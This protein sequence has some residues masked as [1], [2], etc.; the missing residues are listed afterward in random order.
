[1]TQL[2]QQ[3]F[4]FLIAV[5]ASFM[6]VSG[7][8][9]GSVNAEGTADVEGWINSLAET[10]DPCGVAELLAKTGDLRALSPL[11]ELIQR[12]KNK[13]VQ[14]CAA[15]ALA[16][17][18]TKKS[19]ALLIAELNNPDGRAAVGAAF[20]LGIIK[21]DAAVDPLLK[22]FFESETLCFTAAV[23]LG[24]I[25]APRSLDPL[26]GALK[27]QSA[28][29]RRCAIWGLGDFGDRRAC[30]GLLDVFMAVWSQGPYADYAHQFWA[31]ESIEQLQCS[32]DAS[33]T[34]K[35]KLSNTCCNN[36]RQL[37]EVIVPLIE[38]K[39]SPREW[40]SLL[41]NDT[42]YAAFVHTFSDNGDSDFGNP[43]DQMQ[44]FVINSSILAWGEA[45]VFFR[46]APEGET[47]D[48]RSFRLNQVFQVKRL[49]TG[50]RFSCPKIK[51]PD[52]TRD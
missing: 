40:G 39:P 23:A 18:D 52:Y 17:L 19:V 16:N 25:K 4:V 32:F 20:A 42:N 8:F 30:K 2:K 14:A 48:A 11:V 38:K 22:A 9:G 31:L 1:M 13:K 21:D 37:V 44:F 33:Y 6:F 47:A 3:G 45:V 27:N 49:A 36:A 35:Y 7:V 41:Q 34:K 46:Y 43:E 24:S 51:L 5:I 50:I 15:Q 10:D 28:E 12:N 26:I 29:I